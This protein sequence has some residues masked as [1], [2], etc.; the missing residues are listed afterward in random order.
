MRS[1]AEGG[2]GRATGRKNE[3]RGVI[4][5]SVAYSRRRRVIRLLFQ[6]AAGQLFDYDESLKL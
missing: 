2:E 1:M 4:D 3:I 6:A 5:K